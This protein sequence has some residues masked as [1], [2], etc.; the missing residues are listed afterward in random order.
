MA[1][2]LRT[3]PAGVV[4]A[5]L[6][7]AGLALICS[8]GAE[9][10]QQPQPAPRPRTVD[11]AAIAE[12]DLV[13]AVLDECH[14]PLR[15]TMDSIVAQVRP[16]GGA[17]VQLFAILPDK[18]R[19]LEADGSFLLAGDSVF[20]LGDAEAKQATPEAATRVRLL[21]TLLDAATFGPLH[22]ATGCRRTGPGEFELEQKDGSR[23]KL[24]LRDN[25]LLPDSFA[26]S[27]GVVRVVEYLRTPTTWIAKELELD[28]LGRCDVFLKVK[29][30]DW[31]PDFFAPPTKGEGAAKGESRPRNIMP[32]PGPAPEVRSEVPVPLDAK[33]TR[34]VCLA[35]PGNWP[36]RVA[37]YQPVHVELDRQ[38]QLIAGFPIFWQEDGKAWFAAPFRQ[39]PKGPALDAPK[40]WQIRE[41]SAGPA[42]EV[43]PPGATLAQRI[44]TGERLLRDALDAQRLTAAGPILTQ[45][46]LHLEDGEQ[47]PDKIAAAVVRMTVAVR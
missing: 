2:G 45:Y 41:V 35:D 19:V 30:I 4:Y 7:V 8:C 28:G 43:W 29:D 24:R 13:A 40:D 6:T 37:A 14:R 18:L 20:R 38:K 42:W 26:S 10:A 36:A 22:R 46:Y 44:A 17:A 15:G 47:E 31:A 32:V 33:A 34:W 39:R 1:K 11:L 3:Q 12:G 5:T 9:G 23:C 16:A 25:S 27:A 21:R